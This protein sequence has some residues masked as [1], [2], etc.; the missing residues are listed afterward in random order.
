MSTVEK[1]QITKDLENIILSAMMA[2]IDP[3]FEYTADELVK[4]YSDDD[5]LDAFEKARETVV[6]TIGNIKPEDVIGIILDRVQ[7]AIFTAARR[8]SRSRIIIPG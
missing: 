2:R 8:D 1:T 4:Q 5:L 7:D 6:K 3:K